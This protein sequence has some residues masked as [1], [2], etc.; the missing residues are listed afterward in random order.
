VSAAKERG[1]ST[2]FQETS[3][4]HQ[5]DHCL[6]VALNGRSVPFQCYLRTVESP[7]L[8]NELT[9]SAFE[10]GHASR[11]LGGWRAVL[12]LWRGEF[13]QSPADEIR[14]VPAAHQHCCRL[15]AVY[16]S[17]CARIDQPNSVGRAFEQELKHAAIVAQW[18]ALRTTPFVEFG[19]LRLI[20]QT[21]SAPTQPISNPTTRPGSEYLTAFVSK[22]VKMPKQTLV[23][24]N[25]DRRFGQQQFDW[26]SPTCHRQ[27]FVH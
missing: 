9:V 5:H 6:A 19:A 4:R 15:V 1:E 23:G 17:A 14:S 26:T 8:P 25:L 16:D 11:S 27:D 12:L 3:A 20:T 10:L 13:I 18:A 21:S 22:F 2:K 7:R 24:L